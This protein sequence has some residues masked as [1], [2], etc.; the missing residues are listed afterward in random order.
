MNF[1][2]I[3]SMFFLLP[4]LTG[5]SFA[6]NKTDFAV[7]DTIYV[8]AYYAGCVKATVK[9]TE[10][11]YYVHIEEGGYNG[12]DTFYS[13]ER[14]GECPQKADDTK[15][16]NTP[17]KQTDQTTNRDNLTVGDRVDVY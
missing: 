3:L 5:S 9:Q 7:G 4:A 13:A 2:P 8:N 12:K 1:K 14:L 17:D 6:Q 15:T 16:G 10:P 11:K